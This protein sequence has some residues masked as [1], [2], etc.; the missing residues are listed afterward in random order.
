MITTGRQQRTSGLWRFLALAFLFPIWVLPAG[1]QTFINLHNLAFTNGTGPVAN[2]IA[3]GNTLYGTTRIYGGGDAGGYGSVFKM[4]IDGS[5]FTNLHTFSAFSPEAGNLNGGL[6][7]SSSTLYGTASFGGSS[8]YGSLFAIST[9][10][11]GLTN[12]F[13]FPTNDSVFPFTNNLGSYPTAGLI[14][15]GGTLYGVA[16]GGG[17]KGWG[18]LFAVSTNGTAYTNLHSFTF[19]DGQYPDRDLLL[20]GGTLYGTTPVGGS[21]AV[22][23]IFKITTNGAGY[24]NFYNFTQPMAPFFTNSDGA[25]PACSLVLAGSTL[26]GTASEGGDF[27]G[28]TIFKID[29]NG[30]NFSVLHH[31]AATNGPLSTNI[32]GAHPQSGLTLVGSTLY[33]TASAGGVA[34]NGTV[35][36][37]NTDGSSFTTLYQFT[38][39]NNASGTNLDGAHPIGGLL[40]VNGTLY[41]T[42]SFGGTSG[43]G[44]V[45]SIANAPT[46]T[47]TLSG[48]NAILMWPSNV[49]GYNLQGATN[50]VPSATWDPIAG[51]YSVTNPISTRQKFYR[52]NHP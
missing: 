19:T 42:A 10:G 49:I 16:N 32:D 26:Y 52:L 30:M 28:G 35:F 12:F 33:G 48:T 1:A 37:I 51:Q 7:L 50:L 5:G 13:N 22:G 14:L 39:T 46:L 47:I 15:S 20:S 17:T 25:F 3:S 8:N 44:T 34:G 41:G 38:T 23:T 2:L 18:A 40:S 9:N 21:S 27:G 29:T 4:N 6:V 11:L 45:F 24:T 36:K 31:F 43:Y